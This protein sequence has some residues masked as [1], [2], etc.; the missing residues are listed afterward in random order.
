MA[1]QRPSKHLRY[2]EATLHRLPTPS[3]ALI[4]K[5]IY[6]DGLLVDPLDQLAGKL[7]L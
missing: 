4:R 7:F 3:N 5:D 2:L 1:L 6:L